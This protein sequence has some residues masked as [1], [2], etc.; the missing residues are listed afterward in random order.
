MNNKAFTISIALAGLAVFMVYSFITSKEDEI[1]K[2][3]GDPVTVVV[4]KRDI[5]EL[6][7]IY[8]NAVEEVPKPRNFLEP[9][10]ATSKSD[11]VAFTAAVPIRKGE[12][13]T[14]N[15]IIAPGV[16]T[17]LARQIT[18]GKRAISF[19]VGNANAVSRLIKPGDRVDI[20]T[21]IE[22][23]G[24]QKGSQIAKI[25][26]QDVPVLAVGEFIMAHS[27]GRGEKDD[28]T[29]KK[30]VRNMNDDRN[31]DT[32]TLEVDPQMALYITLLRDTQ[33]PVSFLLRNNDDTERVGLNGT[34]LYDV[35]GADAGRL[36][37]APAGGAQK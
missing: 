18:P 7:E 30:V 16:R 19:P 17:G 8:E 2:Q 12:Q 10:Y 21:V 28:I 37:R 5:G 4:A 15:K 36:I 33:Q 9:G 14:M 27:P 13:I 34:T 20:V 25:V 24:G 35:I 3:F 31:F 26:M 32:I 6:S 29:G 23:P 1:K 22:P 11:V